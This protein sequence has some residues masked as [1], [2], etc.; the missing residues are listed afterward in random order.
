MRWAVAFAVVLG[1]AA[2]APRDARA[3]DGP[4]RWEWVQ[5]RLGAGFYAGISFASFNGDDID[6]SPN[7][8]HTAK[9]SPTFGG[10]MTL[11]ISERFDVQG[12]LALAN[13]GASFTD[14]LGARATTNLY[15][16][17]MPLLAR[18]SLPLEKLTPY[19]YGG[20]S[21]GVLVEGRTNDEFGNPTD[22]APSTNTVDPGFVI[23][24]GA[25]IGPPRAARLFFDLRYEVG[26]RNIDDD[27]AG[28]P[29]DAHNSVF[30][31]LG[32]YAF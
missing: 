14:E 24:A 29:R 19:A 3:Q 12:E 23:G 26:L 11:S 9:A 6:D 4:T 22:V 13:K 2:G 15:Y 28:P 17:E 8:T 27:D 18:G 10:L 5:A 1:V 31:L 16:V 7:V 32:G 21:I 20:F 30:S 25:G